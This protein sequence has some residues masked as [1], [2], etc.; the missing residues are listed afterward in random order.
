MHER[1]QW[2]QKE[3][4]GAVSNTAISI[5]QAIAETTRSMTYIP[6]EMRCLL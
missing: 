2:Q 5:L 6:L 1:F 4:G 3:K